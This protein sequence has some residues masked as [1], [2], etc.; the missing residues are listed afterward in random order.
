MR[1]RTTLIAAAVA[2]FILGVVVLF[3]ARVAYR[4]FAPDSVQLSGISG[5]VWNGAAREAVAGDVYLGDLR[6]RF[7]P[8]ALITGKAG[9]AIAAEPIAGFVETDVAVAPGG[10]VHL[11]DL[12]ARLPV[13]A[14]GA[15]A[16]LLGVDGIVTLDFDSLVTRDGLPVE[17]S[18]SAEVADLVI[19]GLSRAPLGG[20]RAVFRTAGGI[21][22]ADVEDLS[23]VLDLDGTVELRPDR[24]YVFAGT[25]A[26][27]NGAPGEVVRQLQYLGSTDARGRHSFRF[28][29]RL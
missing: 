19:S 21:V 4:W 8:Q 28:E 2:I 9:Y 16:P 23:G 27:T 12:A 17:V 25:V 18:G 11:S 15:A 13:A 6:W 22:T 20:Y 10:A 26:A 3:P 7:R 24:S 14:M 5:T 1:R 29:G